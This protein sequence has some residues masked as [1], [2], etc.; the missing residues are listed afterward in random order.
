VSKKPIV[1][2]IVGVFDGALDGL[3]AQLMSRT[4]LGYTVQLL[5]AKDTF[6]QGDILLLSVA[7]FNISKGH[8]D[9]ARRDSM[10][11]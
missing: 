10:H 8:F 7:E 5:E 4:K 2:T 11:P 9:Q 6:H 1:G 3:S